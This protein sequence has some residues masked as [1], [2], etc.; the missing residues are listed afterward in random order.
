[1]EDNAR[2]RTAEANARIRTQHCL[3]GTPPL[4]LEDS[5]ALNFLS[6]E[7]AEV[8]RSR[9]FERPTEFRAA[10]VILGRTRYAEDCFE[11][12]LG[13]GVQQHVALGAGFDSFPLRQAG[14]MTQV[15]F[16]EIDQPA[17]QQWKRELLQSTGCEIPANLEFVP[18]NLERET[19]LQALARS[20]FRCAE[21]AFFSW[22]GNTIYLT[23]EAIFRTLVSFAEELAPGSRIVF[24][25]GVPLEFV[26]PE[27]AE[28]VQ[29]GWKITA[30]WGEPQRSW[31]NP[32]AFPDEVRAVGLEVVENLTPQQMAERYFSGRNDALRPM[33]HQHY[34]HLRVG[35]SEG[36]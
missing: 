6:P 7:V 23:R 8:A 10:A 35:N 17:T 29:L 25:Y 16:Y 24:D 12:T 18:A 21:P 14:S 3:H 4:I 30:E 32:G 22:L 11:Q 31:L 28:V 36:K 1:M 33:T 5:F 27:D 19:V 13:E 2:S 9:G 26:A 20:S 34:I 15:H